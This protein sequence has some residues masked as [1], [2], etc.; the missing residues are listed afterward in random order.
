MKVIFSAAFCLHF[1]FAFAQS[2]NFFLSH[3]SPGK[4]KLDNICFQTR[5]HPNGIMYFATRGGLLEFDGKSWNLING[6]GA[7]Y[8]VLISEDGKI[9]WGGAHGYGVV[10]A[11]DS[12]LPAMK[13]LSESVRDIFQSVQFENKIYFLNDERIIVFDPATQASTSIEASSTTGSFVGIFEIA[14][15]LTIN[16][17]KNGLYKISNGKLTRPPSSGT[18]IGQIVFSSSFKD[19]TLIGT[20]DNEIYVVS[21]KKSFRKIAVEDQRYLNGGVITSGSWINDDLVVL[22][23]LRG[24]LIFLNLTNGKTHEIINYSTGLPDNEI[25]TVA[26]DQ[27]QCVWAA[28]EYGFTRVAPYL[29][30]RS[31]SHYPGLEGNLLC[32]VSFRNSVY[33]GTSL[34]LYKLEKEDVYGERAYYA[35]VDRKKSS[36]GPKTESGS[37]VEDS[38]RKGFFRLFRKHTEE[39]AKPGAAQLETEQKPDKKKRS[40]KMVLKTEKVLLSSSYRYKKVKNIDAKINSLHSFNNKLVACGLG[41]TYDVDGSVGTL[42]LAAPARYIYGTSKNELFV[43]TYSDEVKT[44]FFDGSKWITKDLLK[45]L[46][47]QVSC[48]IEGD[49]GEIWLCALDKIYRMQTQAHEIVDLKVIDIDN[50]NYDEFVGIQLND[51]LIL[52]NSN[53]FYHFDENRNTFTKLDSVTDRKFINYFSGND[54]IWYRHVHGWNTLGSKQ[55]TKNLALLNLFQNIRFISPDSNTENLWVITD[56]N[57]LYRYLPD[58]VNL[59]SKGF[60]LV[61]KTVKNGDKKTGAGKKLKI[62]QENSRLTFEV[63]Q[64]DYLASDAVEY[65]YHITGLE[66]DWTEWSQANN[67]IEI[68]YLPAGDYKLEVESRDIFGNVSSMPILTLDVR[69]PYW[70]TPWFYAL[71]V[72]VFSLLVILSFRLSTRYR[73]ISR[74][75]MLLTIIMLIQF[76]ETI[77]GETLVTKTSPVIDF[78]IQVVIAMMILPIEGYIRELMLRSLDT[79]HRFYRFIAPKITTRSESQAEE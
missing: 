42:L 64:P 53:G 50:P 62:D 36:D 6:N 3:H 32:A 5:Q 73:I 55:E 2:G 76:V 4:D 38:K 17:S 21:E 57:Q 60:P 78:L 29:P 18:P 8:T 69:P 47:D 10:S 28:H 70:K 59:H 1:V 12:N 68:P 13:V 61:L 23:T 43:S 20:S 37:P 11:D 74:L 16:T 65:R 22:G 9:F 30:F 58:K 27:S 14:G 24:G 44:L 66:Q 71:E 45:N 25:F 79:N 31:F 15:A 75:L 7:V 72:L 46:N 34:G 40:G 35:S 49:H 39:P 48:I 54:N 56:D 52:A 51:S 26:T 19:Q 33:V 63:V 41:G 67:V 77:I